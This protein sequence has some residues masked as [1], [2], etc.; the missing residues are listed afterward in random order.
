MNNAELFFPHEE[1]DDLWDLYEER[2]FVDKQFFTSRAII[3]SLFEKR[4]EKIM[5]REEAFR[6]ITQ[7][8][9]KE[10][11]HN[12][13]KAEKSDSIL[14]AYS[15]FQS[16][17]AKIFQAIFKAK[18]IPTLIELVR[19]L[20]NSFITYTSHWSLRE[21]FVTKDILI[22][23]EPEPVALSKAIQSFD[24]ADGKTAEDLHQLTFE[25]KETLIAEAKRLSLWRKKEMNNGNV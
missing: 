14:E 4:F 10:S 20:I 19:E 15:N 18:E 12:I 11:S 7:T 24:A 1:S 17:K 22:S 3:P 13:T 25:G 5:K 2:L 21:S 9:T 6:E 8:T 23:K 16:D